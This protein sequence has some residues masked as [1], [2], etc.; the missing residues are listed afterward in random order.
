[1]SVGLTVAEDAISVER[2]WLVSRP[3]PVRSSQCNVL[4]KA[5]PTNFSAYCVFCTCFSTTFSSKGATLTLA[6]AYAMSVALTDIYG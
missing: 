1:M 5:A 4:L 3:I 6:E 2:M